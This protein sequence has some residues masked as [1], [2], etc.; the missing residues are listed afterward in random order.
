MQATFRP[1][2]PLSWNFVNRSET[3]QDSRGKTSTVLFLH[4]EGV[5]FLCKTEVYLWQRLYVANGLITSRAR[6]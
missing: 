6:L 5:L 3:K 2:T 4:V 1:A